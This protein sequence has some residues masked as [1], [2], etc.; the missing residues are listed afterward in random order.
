M[1]REVAFCWWNQ[2][3]WVALVSLQ[4]LPRSL[5]DRLDALVPRGLA[6]KPNDRYPDHNTW[7]NQWE[8]LKALFRITPE[9]P[10][11]ENALTRVIGWFVNRRV[12]GKRT[13]D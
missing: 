7:L 9:L 13:K 4:Q 3:R 12:D 8:E 5:R 10:P 2:T 11:I 6:L 1:L